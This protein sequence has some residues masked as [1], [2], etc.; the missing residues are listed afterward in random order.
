M[1]DRDELARHKVMPHLQT[2][3]DQKGIKYPPSRLLLRA[4]K[5]T[6][7]LEL[8]AS[9]SP[10]NKLKLLKSYKILA[11]SGK[12]GPK[13]KEGDRQVPEGVYFIN[14]FNPKSQFHLSLGINYP[15]ASDAVLADK[16]HPGGD[17]FIHGSK[18]SI[19]CLAMGDEAIE[20]IYTIAKAC[21][22]KVVV[23]ILPQN[24]PAPNTELWKQLD[25][26]N[27]QF[28]R[29]GFFPK[30]TVDSLGNYQISTNKGKS[31]TKTNVL[32][33]KV[34]KC[35][36]QNSGSFTATNTRSGNRIPPSAPSQ[37]IKCG[38]H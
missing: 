14:R 3:C 20:E 1:I 32:R 31:A 22:N 36:N 34:S 28:E 15:N 11:A 7:Q 17:I 9:N 2:I 12:L 5:A 21:P 19:G 25:S 24:K 38:H 8:W 27:Q 37:F 4:F 6:K 10:T 18:V 35:F 16:Q 13:R 29:T 33:F 30:V 26:I 23:F